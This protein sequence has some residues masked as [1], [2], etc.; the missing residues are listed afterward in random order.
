MRRTPI[1]LI[2]GDADHTVPY[3]GSQQVFAAARPPKFFL[4]LIG[5]PHTPFFGPAGPIIVRSMTDFFDRYLKGRRSAL[6]RLF[7][8]G[9]VPG[10]AS[11]QYTVR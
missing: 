2:H 10:I 3:G 11:L 6:D 9:Q 8:D 1:L 5:G 7:I 4:T